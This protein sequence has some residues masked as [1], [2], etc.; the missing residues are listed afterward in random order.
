[1]STNHISV[2][3]LSPEVRALIDHLGV[4]EEILIDSG[5]ETIAVLRIPGRPKARSLSELITRFEAQE[6][7]TGQPILM[8][9]EYASDMKEIIAS[10]KPRDT[11]A[12]D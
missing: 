12:W 1:M 10:R 2:T 8:D 7:T 4:G 11:S 5:N 3:E 9:E 6:K